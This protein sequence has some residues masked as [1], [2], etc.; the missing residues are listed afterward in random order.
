MK[1][2]TC[3]VAIAVYNGE[4]FIN[5]QLISILNQ[6][7]PVDEVV[8]CDDGSTDKTIEIIESIINK[9]DLNNWHLY[10][11]AANLGASQ[12]FNNA[13][14]K[15]SGDI[16]FF[17][18]QDDIWEKSKVEEIVK[19]FDE[20]ENIKSIVTNFK[21]I[22]GN[23]D[24]LFDDE[25]LDNPWFNCKDY[26]ADQND[27]NLYKVPLSTILIQ[28]VSPGCT[29]A[30]RKEL[31]EDMLKFEYS[32]FYHD[33]KVQLIAGL[34][35]GLYYIDKALTKYRIHSNNTVGIPKCLVRRKKKQYYYIPLYYIAHFKNG[36]YYLLSKNANIPFAFDYE[37][38][39][40][41]LEQY[42]IK[43][44][45][46]ND[47]NA[48]KT[49]MLNRIKLYSNENSKFKYWKAQ[50]KY[51]KHSKDYTTMKYKNCYADP[52][53]RYQERVLDFVAIF[54]H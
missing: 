7:H 40:K 20:N 17:C 22:D 11:N 2:S 1:K 30:M 45:L 23:G 38:I 36:I 49:Y 5:Q 26:V 39:I 3:S 42:K 33:V 37:E 8:I 51:W 47:Y 6:T 50:K 28:C 19:A 35:D 14:K 52:T 32:R 18:D 16:I 46:I 48:W 27:E 43:D 29:Q 34:I 53:N 24:Y 4:K 54:K 41:Q 13:I 15:C 10:R 21:L 25:K 44:H 12:N 9:Y 31:V